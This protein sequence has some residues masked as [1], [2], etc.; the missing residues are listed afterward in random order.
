MSEFIIHNGELYHHGVKGM[1]WGVRK[2]RK[3]VV[4]FVPDK[5]KGEQP[6]WQY[7]KSERQKRYEDDRGINPHR[8]NGTVSR[9]QAN[10]N[11]KYTKAKEAWKQ[12][13]QKAERDPAYKDSAE[14]RKCR[15]ENGMAVAAD[16]LSTLRD[17]HPKR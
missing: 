6:S 4:G 5:P 10:R 7:P 1:K 12:A 3:G 15:V 16:I 8:P 14:Y 17:G 2:A 11:R 9:Y 13:K